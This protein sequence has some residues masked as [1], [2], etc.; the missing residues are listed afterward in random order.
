MVYQNLTGTLQELGYLSSSF[1]TTLGSFLF[2]RP[3]LYG[4]STSYNESSIHR[5]N[6]PQMYQRNFNCIINVNTGFVIKCRVGQK[7]QIVSVK[8]LNNRVKI[9]FIK[10]FLPKNCSPSVSLYYLKTIVRSIFTS[11]VYYLV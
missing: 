9:Q 1:A 2:N 4:S 3:L 6:I 10:V 11:F 7:G 8:V 5:G